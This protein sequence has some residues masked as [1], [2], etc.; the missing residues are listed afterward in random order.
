M[1][2]HF[3]DEAYEYKRLFDF[4][5]EHCKEMLDQNARKCGHC[6]T[7]NVHFINFDCIRY[8]NLRAYMSIK[9]VENTDT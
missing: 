8:H 6:A 3:T 7:F 1:M 5:C 9:N 2:G 4:P